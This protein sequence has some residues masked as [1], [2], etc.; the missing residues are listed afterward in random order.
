MAIAIDKKAQKL[1]DEGSQIRNKMKVYEERLDE[2][3]AELKKYDLP[4]GVYVAPG[5][6]VLDLTYKRSYSAPSAKEL[7]DWLKSKRMSKM[8][9]SCVKVAAKE[10]AATIG[11]DNYNDLRVKN[12]D[13][14]QMSF[15]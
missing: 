4:K 12:A 15:K 3:K 14:P 9:F 10:T 1:I 5:G 8:F 13:I 6:G 11:E 2:I 7:Y